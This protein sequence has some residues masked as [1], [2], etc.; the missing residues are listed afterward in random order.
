MY[1]FYIPEWPYRYIFRVFERIFCMHF[2]GDDLGFDGVHF[3]AEDRCLDRVGVFQIQVG[4]GDVHHAI[5]I[6]GYRLGQ[7]W[8]HVFFFQSDGFC[9][10]G[11]VQKFCVLMVFVH[12]K[13]MIGRGLDHFAAFG[14]DYGLQDVYHLGD[15]CHF[16][17]ITVF[18]EDVQVDTC[19][20]GIAH[21]IL[22][23]QEAR[24]GS[25]F[26]FKPGSPFIDD[27]SN[28]FFRIVFIHDGSMT[29]DQFVH[30]PGLFHGL[31]PFFFIKFGSASFV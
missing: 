18:V 15:V 20:Q 28:F 12:I 3:F 17:T 9:L 2:L 16:Y 5:S 14:Q 26:Y 21:G 30:V 22:L 25:R 29:G 23:I 8:Y 31:V 4:H 24:V 13:Y 10:Q 6:D 11:T 1:F 27:H 19:Y 7:V